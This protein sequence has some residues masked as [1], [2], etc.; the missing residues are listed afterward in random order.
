MT[1]KNLT[2]VSDADGQ[3]LDMPVLSG[4]VGPDVVDIGALYKKLG[5]FTLDPGYVSTASCESKIT[6]IDGDHGRADVPR[7]PGGAARR[8]AQFIEVAYLLLYGEL[9]SPSSS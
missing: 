2:L 7:L 3:R 6:Y 1:N 5:V 8:A 4:T 9:P